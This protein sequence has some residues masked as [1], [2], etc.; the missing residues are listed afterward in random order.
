MSDCIFCKIASGEMKSEFLYEDK[1][2]VAFRD[3][4]PQAP[5]HI[6][7][8]PRRHISRMSEL[9]EK[10]PS[11][12]GAMLAAASHIA[13]KEDVA[14]TGYRLVLNYGPDA[15]QDVEHIHLHLLGGRKMSWPPG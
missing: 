15:G 9:T 8:I 12:A 6:L 4:R 10:E 14:D 2:V 13:K 1:D 5:A 11:L 7:V 3:I